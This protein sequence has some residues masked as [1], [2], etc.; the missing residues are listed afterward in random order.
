MADNQDNHDK[1]NPFPKG[2]T[3]MSAS[4]KDILK[5]PEH[6]SDQKF[7]VYITDG[8]S[9]QQTVSTVRHELEPIVP[10]FKNLHKND[11][12][13]NQSKVSLEQLQA[14]YDKLSEILP[15]FK[16]ILDDKSLTA[17]NFAHEHLQQLAVKLDNMAPYLDASIGSFFGKGQGKTMAQ[18]GGSIMQ[19]R[20]DSLNNNNHEF[21][22]TPKN[23]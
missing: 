7:A 21:G 1:T 10:G 15:E 11:A 6:V 22:H 3:D 8:P 18:V 20:S 16:E 17:S 19:M 13:Y 12:D 4:F 9:I 2:G 14:A 23:K 5:L